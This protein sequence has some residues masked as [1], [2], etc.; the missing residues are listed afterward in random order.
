MSR[1]TTDTSIYLMLPG[2]LSSTANNS[3]I[4]LY[5]DTVGG[6]VDSYVG[7]WY[8]VTGWTS[9]TTIPGAVIDASNALVTARTMRSIYTKDA[10]NK[11]E[12]VDD[13][14]KRAY[15]F[16][17]GVRDQELIILGPAGTE[18]PKATTATLVEA[19]REDFTPIFDIDSD[20]SWKEDSDLLD[21]IA[22]ER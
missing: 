16:L 15:T 14:E 22:G 11:N 18:S 3:L 9:P 5:V 1:Y 20:L 17:E 10:Q 13:W 21:E 19:T 4:S 7:R 12:W 8:Q 6:V 2:I